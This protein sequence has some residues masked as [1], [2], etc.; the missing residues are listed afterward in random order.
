MRKAYLAVVETLLMASVRA[1]TGRAIHS[2]AG[3]L[4]GILWKPVE[5][6]PGHTVREIVRLYGGEIEPRRAA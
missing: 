6:N 1:G 3:Y 2:L 5:I 4:G